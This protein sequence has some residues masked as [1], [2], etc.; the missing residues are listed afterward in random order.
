MAGPDMI[1]LGLENLLHTKLRT[2]LTILGV[3]VGIGALAS[4]VSFGTGMQRNVTDAF[5]QTDLFTS[6]IVTAG[7]IDEI[8][9]PE[10]VAELMKKPPKP[11]TDSTV[12]AIRGVEGVDIVFPQIT[13]P[14]RLEM[15]GR[16]TRTTLRGI[17]AAMGAYKPFSDLVY[18]EFFSKNDERVAVLRMEVLEDM[19]LTVADPDTGAATAPDDSAGAMVAVPP[20]SIIGRPLEVVTAVMDPS[21]IA[22]SPLLGIMPGQELF[23]EAAG[24]LRIVGILEAQND[25]SAQ[26]FRGGIFVPIETAD[27]IPRLG[28]SSVW[29]LLGDGGSHGKYASIYVRVRDMTDLEAVRTALVDEM[30][31]SVFSIAD[32][33]NE[34]KRGFVILDSVLAAVG[35]VALFVAALGI[36]NTMVMSILERTREIGIMKAIGASDAQIRTVFLAEAATIGAAGAVLGLVLGWLVTRVANMV[37]NARFMPAGE[38]PVN[39]FY[40]PAWL[41]LGAIGFSILVSL[42]AGVYP[43]GRAARVD[44]V[45]ALR[46]D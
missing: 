26:G 35:T 3:V 32:Q 31:L 28:F 25:F 38:D 15:N 4:M 22:G 23:Q 41:I 43:A 12:I 36:V 19:G 21:G 13:F 34:I 44:P 10:D 27:S 42:L 37:V 40:F 2:V 1:R 11:L 33:F 45:R 16:E 14:V 24:E 20:D 9:G 7:D 17:P 18:G 39:L 8:S 46:H 6:L 30:G 29:D 5:K